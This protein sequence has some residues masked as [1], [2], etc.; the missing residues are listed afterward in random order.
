MEAEGH[1]GNGMVSGYYPGFGSSGGGKVAAVG[2]GTWLENIFGTKAP[3]YTSYGCEG[4]RWSAYR[5]S[6]LY[7]VLANG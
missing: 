6:Y 5:I 4:S 2:G 1:D 3:G 7:I